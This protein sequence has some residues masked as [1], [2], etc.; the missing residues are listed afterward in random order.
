M[1]AKSNSKFHHS[2]WLKHVTLLDYRDMDGNTALTSSFHVRL[3]HL[4]RRD[5]FPLHTANK[6][7]AAV[8]AKEIYL[9]LVANGWDATL[10]RAFPTII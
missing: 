7:N 6:E 10:A 1:S 3:K 8:L 9:Y 4:G 5:R 2:Y